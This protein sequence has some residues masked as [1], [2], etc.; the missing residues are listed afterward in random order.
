VCVA[1]E[2]RAEAKAAA[3][4][5]ESAELLT[6]RAKARLELPVRAPSSK[7]DRCK[8]SST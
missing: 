1:R 2:A 8:C 3:K 6:V 4:A 5:E 7:R